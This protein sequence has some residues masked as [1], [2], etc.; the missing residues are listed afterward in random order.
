MIPESDI[1]LFQPSFGPEELAAVSA[2]FDRS[3]VGLGGQVSEFEC[4]FASYIGSNAALGLNSGTAALQLAVE[5]FGFPEGKKVL[6]N[7]LTFVASATCI[8]INRLTP[9]LVDCDPVSLGFD[10]KDAANKVDADT[11]AIVVVHYGG[12]PTPMDDLM[13]FAEEHGLKVIEDC[14]HCIG[15]SWKGRK[16]GTWGHVGCFSFEEKKGMTTGDGGM[17]VSDDTELIERMKPHRWVGIDKDTWRRRGA[18][19]DAADID[20]RHWH[21]EVA[22]LGY[23]YNMN[24]LAASIGRVQ[25]RK[26]DAMNERKRVIIKRYLDGLHDLPGIQPLLPYDPASGAYW[27]FGIRTKRREHL[28][29]HLKRQRIATGV[30]YMPMSLHPLFTAYNQDLPISNMLWQDLLTLPLH[31]ELTDQEVDRVV[32]AVKMAG[33]E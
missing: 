24:D 33:K 30:H 18:Y 22:V 11:V 29:R 13:R 10:L 1:R 2:A 17:M 16:L 23:K 27:L 8:L 14:A 26:L 25:L 20:T 32:E 7:N 6:V 28:I 5:A 4:E 21:Y 15:G 9:V 3:W 31:A 19:T 12:Q